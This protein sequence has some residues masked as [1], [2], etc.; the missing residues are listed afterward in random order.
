MEMATA[1]ATITKTRLVGL[2]RATLGAASP[3][4]LARL[5]SAVLTFGLPLCLVRLLD[6]LAFGTYKQ[7]F[8][9]ISTVLLIGQLGVTQSLYYF[10]PRGGR[11]R[12]S[13]LSQAIALLWILAFVFAIAIYAAAPLIAG[14]MH[15]PELVALRAPL[16]LTCA[17][18]LAAAPLEPALTSD[19]R[20]GLSALAYVATDATRAAALVI[21]ARWG[22]RLYGP[23]ALFWAAAAATALRLVALIALLWRGVL[24]FERPERTR[25]VEQLRFALPFAG[26]SALQIGQRYSAQYAVSARFDP[27]TF[28]IFTIAS[29]HLPMVDIVFAPITEVLMVTLGRTIGHDDR[30]SLVQF[31]G[32]VNKMA[33]LLFPLAAGSWL[34]GSTLL[35][36]LF[37]A[38]YQAAVP[39]FFLATVEIPFCILP[40]DALLRAAGDTKYLFHL[41]AARVAF[42]VGLVLAGIRYAGLGGALFAVISSEIVSRLVMLGRGR[43]FLGQPEFKQ[44]L[45]W[46]LL[47]RLALASALACVPTALVRFIVAPGVG[48]VVASIS[49]YVCAYLCLTLLFRSKVAEEKV[50]AAALADPV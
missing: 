39:L 22:M 15:S 42:T 23:A 12:G 13:Y 40:V 41:S 14:W 24:P 33:A 47:G 1:M 8:L 50:A 6:P 45:D 17:L 3:L 43:R 37:T 20:I 11:K 26:A 4:V 34:L 21:G 2:L 30:A 38:K 35:P 32:A 49:V 29:F 19:G 36:L 7:F 44:L 9:L 48:R 27:A 18:M 10:L 31:Q 46:P 5:L 16:A 28:P 25:V